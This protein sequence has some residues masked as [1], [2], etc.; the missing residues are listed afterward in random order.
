VLAVRSARPVD[1]ELLSTRPE[2]VPGGSDPR[3]VLRLSCEV[4]LEVRLPAGGTRADQM[5]ALDQTLYLLEDASLADGSALLPADDADPGFRIRRLRL[6][7]A[8]PPGAITVDAQGLFWPVGQA[9]EAGPAIREVRLRQAVQPLALAPTHPRLLAGGAP[10][11]LTVTLGTTATLRIEEGGVT[12]LPFGS[13]S[14]SVVDA[15]GRPGAGTLAGG[16]AG[17]GGARL[18]PVAAGAATVVY[19][20]PAAPAVD[21]L[22]VA[23]EDGEGGPGIELA[24]FRLAVRGA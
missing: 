17:P 10:V 6:A 5:A 22:V 9:G 24:R 14:L 2:R 16:V 1:E 7:R 4:G 15:G 20:P 23:L 19:T 21:H 11:E 13:L 3:R 12:A 8:E 18:V